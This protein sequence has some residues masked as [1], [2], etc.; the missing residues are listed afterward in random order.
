MISKKARIALD[1]CM[2]VA[3]KH[4]IGILSMSSHSKRTACLHVDD[5]LW[6]NTFDK[7]EWEAHQVLFSLSWKKLLDADCVEL[8]SWLLFLLRFVPLD[9]APSV[10]L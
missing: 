2:D 8:S 3:R 5:I 10:P 1:A 6:L 7:G 4:E 9:F